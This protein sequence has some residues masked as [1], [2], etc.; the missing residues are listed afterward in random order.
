[1]AL[2]LYSKAPDFTL[3]CTTGSDFTLSKDMAGQACIIYFYPKGFTPGC[4]AEAC[5]FR[6][7]FDEFRDLN[8]PIYGISKDNIQS[9]LAFKKKHNLPFELLSDTSGKV[10][11][12]YKALIPIIRLPKRVTYLLDHTHQVIAIYENLFGYRKHMEEMIKKVKA[13]NI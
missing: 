7:A 4:T 12:S 5:T 3:P 8:F 11:R 10:C 1:M 6:D 13:S 2:S 9:H